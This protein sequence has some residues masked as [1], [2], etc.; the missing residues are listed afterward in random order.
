[1]LAAV[2]IGPK[3][4]G[5]YDRH[6]LVLGVLNSVFALSVNFTLGYVGQPNFGQALFF[7]LG[8]YT[9]AILTLRYGVSFVTSVA[10]AALVATVAGIAFGPVALRLR[11]AYF[12]MVTIALTQAFMLVSQNL[13]DLTGGPMGLPGI[14]RGEILG[15][16]LEGYNF[17]LLALLVLA[18]TLLATWRFQ[19]SV[20]GRAWIGMRESET[21]ARS[22]GIDTYSYAV[23]AYVIGAFFAGVAGGLHAHYTS[24][25]DPNVFG[26]S[27][28]SLAVVATVLGGGGTVWGPVCG[29]MAITLLPEYLRLAEMW[30]LPIFGLFLIAVVV[31][32][33]EGLIPVLMKRRLKAG[34]RFSSQGG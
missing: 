3:W 15:L 23:L 7:G 5:P 22:V 17:W 29:A 1:L 27:W 24:L 8:A 6:V 20:V 25:V 19:H 10:A 14:P 30:R 9:S 26:F 12:C 32:M 11:G 33:P 31:G 34:P 18:V 16:R 4:L 2:V 21:L 28:S 13:V